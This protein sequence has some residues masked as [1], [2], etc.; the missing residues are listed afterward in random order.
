MQT[1]VIIKVNKRIIGINV[2]DPTQ[3]ASSTKATMG[4]LIFLSNASNAAVR[5][6]KENVL[7]AL[8]MDAEERNERD[9]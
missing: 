4:S 3:N 7:C 8:P 6:R 9:I 1:E 5:K 2:S